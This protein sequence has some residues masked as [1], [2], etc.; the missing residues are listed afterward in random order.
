MIIALGAD[1]AGLPLKD[2]L[3]VWLK[4][5]GHEALDQGTFSSQS[6]DYPVFAAAVAEEVL[7]GRAERGLLVCG[8]GIGMAVAA[9]RF[10]GIRAANCHDLYAA[11]LCREHNDANVL[12]LGAR[13]LGPG[14]A[15]EIVRV[16]LE[17]GFLGGRH[18][19]RI[20]QLDRLGPGRR[21]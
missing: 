21:P 6:C 4:D 16:W 15:R 19:R 12:T 13:I 10:P 9:N 18:Q 3:V 2:E 14:L 20:D 1:H 8:S 11:R 5:Q 17:T 7:A